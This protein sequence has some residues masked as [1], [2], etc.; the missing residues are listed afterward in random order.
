MAHL[1]VNVSSKTEDIQV[2]IG[3]SSQAKIT[4]TIS[5]TSCWIFT[6]T[7][8]FSDGDG[9][10][11][12]IAKM[13][14]SKTGRDVQMPKNVYCIRTITKKYNTQLSQDMHELMGRCYKNEGDALLIDLSSIDSVT[15]EIVME[16][17]KKASGFGVDGS[18]LRVALLIPQLDLRLGF[19]GLLKT[20]KTKIPTKAFKTYEHAVQYLITGYKANDLKKMEKSNDIK[21]KK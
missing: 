19:I 12:A 4:E 11:R 15:L 6:C 2:S 16:N 20:I 9:A 14:E 13:I 21:P 8:N 10:M 17:L 1:T 18:L 7:K 3:E 5:E